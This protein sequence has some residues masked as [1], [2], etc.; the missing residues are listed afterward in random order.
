M[1]E[2]Q[3]CGLLEYRVKETYIVPGLGGAYSQV[4]ETDQK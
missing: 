2:V 3:G 4:G 1:Y